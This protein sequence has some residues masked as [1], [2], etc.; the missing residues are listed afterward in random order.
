[1]KTK[2]TRWHAKV[3]KNMS[4]DMKG[5]KTPEQCRG[6][7]KKLMEKYKSINN[8]IKVLQAQ[9]LRFKKKNPNA[10]SIQ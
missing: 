9:A 4:K 1:M 6:H 10:H 2:S 7:H 8:I 5:K 3:F